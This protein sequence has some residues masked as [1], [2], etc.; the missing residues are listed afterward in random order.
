M[1]CGETRGEEQW[2]KR[3]HQVGETEELPN[4]PVKP[5]PLDSPQTAVAAGRED[6]RFFLL[7][8]FSFWLCRLHFP[9]GRPWRRVLWRR[10][11]NVSYPSPNIFGLNSTQS[12]RVHLTWQCL[13]TWF[14]HKATSSDHLH[15]QRAFLL[16]HPNLD[17]AWLATSTF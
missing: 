16:H 4:V 14:A 2:D 11:E 13:R 9:E 10:P 5:S 15:L 6:P 1:T 8:L 3:T 17:V 12:G 7:L